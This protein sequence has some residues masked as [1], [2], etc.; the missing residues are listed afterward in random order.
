MRDQR[1]TSLNEGVDIYLEI[2]KKKVFAVAIHWPGWCRFGKDEVMALESLD[3]S[4]D[5]YSQVA[6]AGGVNFKLPQSPSDFNIVARLEG[7]ST[8][9][10]G[11]PAKM[12]KNEWDLTNSQELERYERII[13]G[14]W[15]VFDEAVNSGTGKE[16]KKGIRGGGRD[17]DKII[18]HV[19][20]AEE[21]YLKQLGW[22]FPKLEG[23]IDQRMQLLQREVLKGLKAAAAGLL[24]RIGPRGGKRWPPSFFAR[25]LA[26]HVLDHAWEIEDRIVPALEVE[27]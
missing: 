13:Q 1:V 20:Q 9:D 22:T 7:D 8:T 6:E 3:R 25:R 18:D 27:T 10:F 19:Y 17:L 24:P 12:L 2:G 11:A 21:L 4:A 14:C 5:R 26:W 15:F 16:I 23:E